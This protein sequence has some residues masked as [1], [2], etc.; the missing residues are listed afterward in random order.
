MFFSLNNLY[1]KITF[2]IIDN[3]NRERAYPTFI[4]LN[5]YAVAKVITPKHK[6]VIKYIEKCFLFFIQIFWLLNIFT[7][8]NE[9]KAPNK[10]ETT[11]DTTIE[12]KIITFLIKT[13]SIAENINA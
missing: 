12:D 11:K 3:W 9:N 4:Y 8:K 13:A 1:P 10:L 6:A 5:T 7:R 2:K